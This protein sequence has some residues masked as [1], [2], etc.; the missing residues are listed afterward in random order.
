M[1]LLKTRPTLHLEVP[2]RVT[3][4][5]TLS[6]NLVLDVPETIA[7][8]PIRIGVQGRTGGYNSN[9]FP[10]AFE[11][12]V[13][14]TE[15]D[16]FEPGQH[17]VPF[18]LRLPHEMT[19]TY[20]TTREWRRFSV[21]AEVVIPWWLDAS[22]EQ[23]IEV[24][25][26]FPD[27][28]DAESRT[29]TS[30]DTED[31]VGGATSIELTIDADAASP[32]DLITG[33]V[34]LD[35]S[36]DARIRGLRVRLDEWLGDP[37]DDHFNSFVV[38]S[39]EAAT[40]E[41]EALRHGQ[42]VDFSLEVPAS[43]SPSFKGP[44]RR[45]FHEVVVEVDDGALVP[46]GKKSILCPVRILPTTVPVSRREV[47]RRALGSTRQEQQFA[48]VAGALGAVARGRQL[49]HSFGPVRV[50]V[51]ARI[52]GDVRSLV[53]ELRYPDL[54]LGLAVRPGN[55]LSGGVSAT[56]REPRQ[57]SALMAE[58]MPLLPSFAPFH[59]NDT[60]LSVEAP[61]DDSAEA[62][63]TFASRVLVLVTTLE[64]AMAQVPPPA[65]L[66]DRVPAFKE[67]AQLLLGELHQGAMI[68]D[69]TLGEFS[70][71]VRPRWSDHDFTGFAVRFPFDTPEDV[72]DFGDL[73]P[74][75]PAPA[76]AMLAQLPALQVT[77]LD[78]GLEFF[79]PRPLVSTQDMLAWLHTLAELVVAM[80]PR[81]SPYR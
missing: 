41:F 40:I 44:D 74:S 55:F 65:A 17:R 70:V 1:R 48:E 35:A 2:A 47:R 37:F 18:A 33:Q 4:G 63:H 16:A 49:M 31:H 56:G 34:A 67:L 54:G 26:A 68:V 46:L 52:V 5:R 76:R 77:L 61:A 19:P 81:H 20:A 14:L 13:R 10:A 8:G 29:I 53:A 45:R 39:I 50:L 69:G 25:P 75:L 51:F 30:R 6:G 22:A 58:L 12:F 36:P 71:Q 11:R 80:T 73:G 15:E 62:L 66:A 28:V 72:P 27:R 64:R 42:A 59:G 24:L 79:S 7:V 32:G 78:K 21:R 43:F 3:V 38:R 57:I 60:E 23:F 9:I